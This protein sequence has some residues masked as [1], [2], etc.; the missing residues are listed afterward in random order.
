MASGKKNSGSS[1]R[2]SKAS[3]TAKTQLEESLSFLSEDYDPEIDIPITQIRVMGLLRQLNPKKDSNGLGKDMNPVKASGTDDLKTEKSI[4]KNITEM[5]IVEIPWMPSHCEACKTFNH[6]SKNCPTKGKQQTQQWITKAIEQAINVIKPLAITDTTPPTSRGKQDKVTN[7]NTSTVVPAQPNSKSS[8]SSNKAGKA[9]MVDTV[10]PNKFS[11]LDSVLVEKK[12]HQQ[13]ESRKGD[14]SPKRVRA[15]STG[16]QVAIQQALPRKKILPN[17]NVNQ[18]V[19]ENLPLKVL[20][21]H[22]YEFH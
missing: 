14:T 13:I 10:S 16:V 1:N 18:K 15:A 2:V 12:V 17:Q 20:H 8:L 11:I 19:V 9:Q 3:I 7:E 5:L 21:R 6:S 22:P 4:A